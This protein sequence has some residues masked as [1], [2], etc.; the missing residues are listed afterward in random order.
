MHCNGQSSSIM[1]L[2]WVILRGGLVC[3]SVLST[4]FSVWCILSQISLDCELLLVE[5]L[6]L[7]LKISN[8]H[9]KVCLMNSPRL[10]SKQCS[11]WGYHQSQLC[12]NLS[13]MCLAVLL[14]TWISLTKFEAVSIQ[15]NQLNSTCSLLTCLSMAQSNRW[16]LLPRAQ[17][18]P[19]VWV[20]NHN[21]GLLICILGNLCTS[22]Y[23]WGSAVWGDAS[24]TLVWIQ[25]NWI[26]S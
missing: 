7:M 25:I 26:V 24:E 23:W 9:W 6:P 18:A 2:A 11:G 4:L 16:Q 20:G 17:S 19:L 3:A 15:V 1:S 5:Y 22:I 8:S 13:H 14:S 21:H 12:M 10:S